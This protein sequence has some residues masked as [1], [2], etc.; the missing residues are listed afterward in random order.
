MKEKKGNNHS[1]KIINVMGKYNLNQ[2]E[3]TPRAYRIAFFI[4]VPFFNFVVLIFMLA[5]EIKRLGWSFATFCDKKVII[6]II[7]A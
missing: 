4:I 6:F 2:T 5:Y 1:K 7:L 3:L